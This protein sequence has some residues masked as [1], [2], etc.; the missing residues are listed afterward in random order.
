VRTVLDIQQIIANY[1]VLLSQARDPLTRA[2]YREM[3][4]EHRTQLA[5]L[6]GRQTADAT[7]REQLAI[8]ENVVA[9]LDRL[10]SD[11]S[12]PYLHRTLGMI[13][14]NLRVSIEFGHFVE[15]RLTIKTK[16]ASAGQ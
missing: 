2:R 9:K 4:D 5:L 10:K 1:E 3:L 6:K 13:S 12:E 15:R 8:L 16:S 14:K 11:I 7:L